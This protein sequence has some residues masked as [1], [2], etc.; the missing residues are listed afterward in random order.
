MTLL[1][2]RKNYADRLKGYDEG[3]QAMKH[4]VKE[5]IRLFGSVHKAF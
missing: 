2:C 5:K 1:L 4:P 3:I